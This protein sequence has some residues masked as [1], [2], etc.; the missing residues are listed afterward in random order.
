MVRLVIWDA[1][2]PIMTSWFDNM[3]VGRNFIVQSIRAAVTHCRNVV[4]TYKYVEY[5]I[6]SYTLICVHVGV[7]IINLIY[8][9]LYDN[10]KLQ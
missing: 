4:I 2:A 1:I 6:L 7:R 10:I 9:K 8:L 3:S 5:N